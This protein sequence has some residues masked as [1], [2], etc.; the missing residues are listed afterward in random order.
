MT[1][2]RE[3]TA[4]E[5]N[6]NY[7]GNYRAAGGAQENP[8][9]DQPVPVER[10]RAAA[11]RLRISARRP[12]RHSFLAQPEAV[13]PMWPWVNHASNQIRARQGGLHRRSHRALRRA[14]QLLLHRAGCTRPDRRALG[15]R[16]IRVPGQ[17]AAVQFQGTALRLP[18]SIL[19]GPLLHRTPR[20]IPG[21]QR[22]TCRRRFRSTPHRGAGARVVAPSL[23]PMQPD[24]KVASRDSSAIQQLAKFPVLKRLW[25]P[26]FSTLSR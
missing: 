19:R 3:V 11:R 5:I 1:W 6:A 7:R 14:A 8:R 21:W 9:P 25:K 26:I 4:K 18:V 16:Q 13:R 24:S 15:L 22:A 2:P 10:E 12:L 17:P 23:C 20:R